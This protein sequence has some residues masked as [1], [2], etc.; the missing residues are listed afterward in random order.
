MDIVLKLETTAEVLCPGQR[1]E[2]TATTN[3]AVVQWFIDGSSASPDAFDENVLHFVSRPGHLVEIKAAL[4]NSRSVVIT[5]VGL[6]IEVDPGPMNGRY[7]I[8]AEPAMPTSIVAT[9]IPLLAGIGPCFWEVKTTFLANDCPP[10]GPDAL[11]TEVEYPQTAGGAVLVVDFGSVISGG[12]ISISVLAQVGPCTIARSTGAVLIGTNPDGSEVEKALPHRALRA[13]ACKESG[14]RQFDGPA[15]GGTAYCPFFG[16]DGEV[17]VMQIADPNSNQIWDWRANVSAGVERFLEKVELAREYPAKVR[18]SERFQSLVAHHN[19]RRLQEMLN[20]IQVVLPDFT[21]G[22]FDGDLGQLEL[23][24]VRGYDGWFGGDDFGF[25]LHEFKV[26]TEVVEGD[27][28]LVMESV[29]EIAL[30]G[31]ARWERVRPGDRPISPGDP[32][33]VDGVLALLGGCREGGAS[34]PCHT[35]RVLTKGAPLFFD[36]PSETGLTVVEATVEAGSLIGDMQWCRHALENYRGEVTLEEL[37]VIGKLSRATFRARHPGRQRL[38]FQRGDCSQVAQPPTCFD[39]VDVSVPHFFFLRFEPGFTDDLAR[40]GLMRRGNADGSPLSDEQLK[41]NDQVRAA[42]IAGA[43]R[44]LSRNFAQINARF[45]TASPAGIVGLG[46]FTAVKIGGLG[47]VVEEYG[48]TLTDSAN[49]WSPDKDVSIWTA[50]LTV[51]Q[52]GVASDPVHKAI[53][54][55]LAVED[56]N[57]QSLGGTPVDAG[58]FFEGV[59]TKRELHVRAAVIAFGNFVGDVASHECGHVLYPFQGHEE[60]S[61]MQPGG[62]FEEKCGIRRFDPDTL[63]LTFTDTLQF[64]PR[65]LEHLRNLYPAR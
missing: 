14:Q 57:G 20:P 45:V 18:T 33:Y 41:T 11:I 54:G 38:R 64:G 27:A 40:L 6:A 44:V 39:N 3:G 47:P 4:D 23:D 49:P 56:T 55:A 63:T 61:V 59:P 32:D 2:V 31:I 5:C 65:Y 52:N 19:A 21:V 12:D 53:F 46:N 58:D 34:V 37:S 26:G 60:N 43:W 28:S 51:G 16:K 15:D 48:A 1:A 62:T 9:A 24:A 36:P 22:D 25:E 7:A 29:D 10:G 13:I 35:V 17:G 50:K 42:V 8:S 30:T